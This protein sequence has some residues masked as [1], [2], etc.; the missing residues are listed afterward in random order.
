MGRKHYLSI[1]AIMMMFLSSFA[2]GTDNDNKNNTAENSSDTN[3]YRELAVNVFKYNTAIGVRGIGTSG[4][5]IKHFTSSATALEGIL[6]LGPD[7]FSITLLYEKYSNAFSEPGLNW[8][9]GVGGH[10]ATQTDW[11]Y[12]DGIRKYRREEGDFGIGV[13]GIFGIEYKIDEVPIAVSID[14]KPFLEVTMK[15]DAYLAIDPGL[16]IKF[17]F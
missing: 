2:A 4:L 11:V 17:A 6:G 16:G 8:Y 7:A 5:T 12:Y 14:V 13:D 10:I 9:Y 1:G 3:P 15:G